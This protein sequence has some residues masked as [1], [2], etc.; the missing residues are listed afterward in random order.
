MR[1][2]R[3]SYNEYSVSRINTKL[4]LKQSLFYASGICAIISAVDDECDFDTMSSNDDFL[5]RVPGFLRRESHADPVVGSPSARPGGGSRSADPPTAPVRESAEIG[6][7]TVAPELPSAR[8]RPEAEGIQPVSP[9]P[10]PGGDGGPPAE[11]LRPMLIADHGRPVNRARITR[12]RDADA[13]FQVTLPRDLIRQ[14]RIRAAEEETTHR[15]IILRALKLYGFAVAD[16]ED[17]DK[18]RAGERGG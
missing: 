11:M 8:G 3:R 6:S 1:T 12:T 15:A 13:P 14:I 16:G 4:T 9:R 17:V 18:R 5:S 7:K 2:S 10:A